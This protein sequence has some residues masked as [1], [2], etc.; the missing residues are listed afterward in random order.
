[1]EHDGNEGTDNVTPRAQTPPAYFLGK[2]KKVAAAGATRGAK[3]LVAEVHPTAMPARWV[4][5]ITQHSTPSSFASASFGHCPNDP[6]LRCAAWRRFVDDTADMCRSLM[7][8]I[9]DLS[10]EPLV[11]LSSGYRSYTGSVGLLWKT[12]GGGVTIKTS[13]QP[14][15]CGDCSGCADAAA[16]PARADSWV[17]FI[18]AVDGGPV[19]IGYS[20]NPRAR[21]SSMQTGRAD[22]LRI[23]ALLP[24][25]AET[26]VAM[27]HVF[28]KYRVRPRGEWFHPAPTILAFIAELAEVTPP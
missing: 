4:A 25:G 19:K 20:S 1:M 14:K 13:Q 9:A 28:R 22:Q 26:E 7:R 21:L 23:L 17:Y 12:E 2:W 8:S 5:V 6:R 16:N 18:Q 10:A 11:I 15:A 27:H 3:D 24:G